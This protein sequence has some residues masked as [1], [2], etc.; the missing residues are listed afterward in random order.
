MIGLNELSKECYR[1]A[2]KRG[3]D[4][5]KVLKHCAGEVIEAAEAENNLLTIRELKF[6]EDTACGDL[7]LELADIIICCLTCSYKY[8]IDI[9]KAIKEKIEINRERIK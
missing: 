6:N 4:P 1:I 3:Q 9:E 8:D 2:E 7:S 5:D